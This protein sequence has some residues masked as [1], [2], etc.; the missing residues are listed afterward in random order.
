MRLAVLMGGRSG[1]RE[2]SL[3]SGAGVLAALRRQGF[4]AVEIDPGPD[5]V[6]QLRQAGAEVVFNVLH[7]GAGEN[8]AIQ[9]VLE[10]AGIPYTGCGVLASAL[11]MDKV[12]S[13]RIFGAVGV[14]TPPHVHFDGRR[15]AEEFA[16][17]AI[18][19]FGLPAVTKPRAEGSS[20]GVSIP[21]SREQLIEAVASIRARYGEGIIDR[22]I[23]GTEITVGIVGVGERTRALP[24]LELVP[25]RE[26][27]DYKA[28]YTK[29]LTELIAPARIS[30]A[31]T[32]R[33][34]ELALRAHQ[35]LGC[36]GVSRVDMH[37]ETDGTCWVHEINS[38]PGM[39]E[40]SD[41][42]HAAAAE[43]VGYDELVLQILESATIRM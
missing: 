8:G 30:D 12:Q 35:A 11:T 33:S 39:T 21:K 10:V 28:K 31:L 34:Q 32:A 4:D 24:V 14:P 18:E 3:R 40:T 20:L 43:G 9:G 29:G 38:V 27:Y 17:Q 25:K 41:L 42:P 7:G 13:K 1:E 23:P 26:F 19:S 36:T 2:V 22:F 37:I 6:T 5:L 16:Q 15:S